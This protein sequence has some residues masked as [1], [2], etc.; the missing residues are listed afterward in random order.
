MRKTENF[1]FQFKWNWL[2]VLCR[3]FN[4]LEVVYDNIGNVLAKLCKFSHKR[5]LCAVVV[6]IFTITRQV[7]HVSQMLCKYYDISREFPKNRHSANRERAIDLCR[8]AIEVYFDFFNFI[9]IID[10]DWHEVFLL[11]NDIVRWTTWFQKIP[12]KHTV[13][14][15][16]QWRPIN[17]KF[18]LILSVIVR[19][20]YTFQWHHY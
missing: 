5:R 15:A 6:W 8:T 14:V 16:N 18:C 11:R 19:D 1:F 2:H 12:R 10:P 17:P 4:H 7:K 3:S 9:V 13:R 20:F